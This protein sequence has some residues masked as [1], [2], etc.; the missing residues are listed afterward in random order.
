MILPLRNPGVG[1][2]VWVTCAY[3]FRHEQYLTIGKAYQVLDIGVTDDVTW[4]EV[5]DDRSAV[6]RYPESWF[7]TPEVPKSAT[8][9]C[10]IHRADCDYHRT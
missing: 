7:K 8:C 6:F 10:G 5:M 4:F 1:K 2:G 9:A 3:N